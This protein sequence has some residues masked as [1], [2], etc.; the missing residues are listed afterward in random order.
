MLCP[1]CQVSVMVP[2]AEPLVA[3][4]SPPMPPPVAQSVQPTPVPQVEET[5]AP[6]TP[7]A[8][9]PPAAPIQG[10]LAESAVQP[11]SAASRHAAI[12]WGIV[13]GLLAV[14][15]YSCLPAIGHL[16]DVP[17]LPWVRGLLGAVFLQT[18]FVLWMLTVRHWSALAIVGL[19]F[20]L[21]SAGYASVAVVALAGSNHILNSWG[22]ESIRA[23]AAVWSAT[24][25]AV[26]L[27]ATYSCVIGTLRWRQET[28]GHIVR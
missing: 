19:L 24:V 17:M 18:V 8:A 15:A 9:L 2:E 28:S 27:L 26:Y 21:T 12:P 10:G 4:T 3:D 25:L 6:Q 7:V 14:L 5:N 20:A 22:M 1:M 16:G 23:R 11:T 13:A